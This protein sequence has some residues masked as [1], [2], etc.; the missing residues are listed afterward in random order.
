MSV[1]APLLRPASWR[2]SSGAADVP[3]LRDLGLALLLASVLALLA[4]C[5]ATWLESWRHREL[6]WASVLALPL[7]VFGLRHAWLLA[8]GWL[9][10]GMPLTLR[11]TGPVA[12][13]RSGEQA[14]GWRVDEWGAEPVDV[15]LVWDWQR[16]MLLRVRPWESASRQTWVWL[17][18]RPGAVAHPG[19]EIHRLRTLLCLPPTMTRPASLAA[20]LPQKGRRTEKVDRAERAERDKGA[21]VSALSGLMASSRHDSPAASARMNRGRKPAR[22]SRQRRVRSGDEAVSSVP[23]RFE[24]DFPATQVLERW[25]D[26]STDPRGV[27]GGRP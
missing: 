22:P 7:C 18:D 21:N 14:G 6:G 26:E 13:L 15:S 12:T 23:L 8:R 2:L 10:P 5:G 4:W 27:G 11:W 19:G 3:W 1:L 16:V 25:Q 9:A 20:V 24:D 17:Q